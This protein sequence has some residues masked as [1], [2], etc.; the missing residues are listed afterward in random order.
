MVITAWLVTVIS[1][2]PQAVIFRVLKH[3]ET[4]FYQCTTVNY[5]ESWATNVTVGNKTEL[6][7]ELLHSQSD[8]QNKYFSLAARLF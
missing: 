1:A 8:Y 5:F 3:P 4:E 2:S 7:L 6:R